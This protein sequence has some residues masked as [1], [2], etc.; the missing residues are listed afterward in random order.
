MGLRAK[1]PGKYQDE[2]PDSLKDLRDPK[3]NKKIPRV[4]LYQKLLDVY[5]AER[6]RWSQFKNDARP[7]DFSKQDEVNSYDSKWIS[8]S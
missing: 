6:F 1:K 4:D 5:E 8:K 3:K 2:Q 7:Q